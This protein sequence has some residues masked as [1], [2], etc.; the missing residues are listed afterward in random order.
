MKQAKN[1]FRVD[2]HSWNSQKFFLGDDRKL[3]KFTLRITE[4]EEKILNKL[5]KDLK[6][7][8]NKIL[9]EMIN[10]YSDDILRKYVEQ[11]EFIKTLKEYT[12]QYKKFGNV[13]NDINKNFYQGQKVKI[14]EIDG[15]LDEIWE[16]I[17]QLKE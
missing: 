12:T 17:K 3:K 16:Y 7:S 8:K 2:P 14:D 11:T 10:L 5:S 13:L 4:E 9:K 6:Q 15:V 1:F